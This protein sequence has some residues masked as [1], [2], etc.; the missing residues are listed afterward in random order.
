M[1]DDDAS[2]DNNSGATQELTEEHDQ[3]TAQAQNES[4][5]Q[6][7]T[8]EAESQASSPT[9][10]PELMERLPLEQQKLIK[11]ELNRRATNERKLKDELK[12]LRLKA[13][14]HDEAQTAK[15]S[16]E[17]KADEVTSTMRSEN[18]GLRKRLVAQE[19]K[20]RAAAK[21]ADPDDPAE[22]LAGQID[23]LLDDDLEPDGQAIDDVLEDLLSR[24]P[25]LAKAD[26]KPRPPAPTKAQGSSGTPATTA[27]SKGLAEAQRR[28]GQKVAAAS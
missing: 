18:E 8:N 2:T 21:F 10:L 12:E 25:H 7:D 5:E 19:I 28:F 9:S 6:Q 27:G 11:S 23:E 20:V 26:P 16:A 1:A 3:A 13:A 22:L 17:Q 4:D 15:K 14:E 24:K